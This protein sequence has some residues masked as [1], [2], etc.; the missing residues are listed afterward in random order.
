MDDVYKK[1]DPVDHL[2]RRESISS[3][4][5]SLAER[6]KAER[7]NL[8]ATADV[9]ELASGMRLSSRTT[10]LGQGGCF[11]DTLLPFPANS[12]V[13]IGIRKGQT[14]F[15]T[16]GV[17]V[18]SQTGLGMGIAF[19]ENAPEQRP[20]FKAWLDDFTSGREPLEKRPQEAQTLSSHFSL[21]SALI[22]LVQVLIKKGILT[23]EEGSSI[24]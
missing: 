2:G 17:V 4:T 23:E 22:R 9:I 3:K 5:T 8:T 6:R 16:D 21:L 18:Y 12:K 20:S 24:L 7:L 19:D 15:E 10:D 13:H 14:K 11:V 1:K